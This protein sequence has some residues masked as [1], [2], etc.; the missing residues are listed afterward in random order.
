[1]LPPKCR[2]CSEGAGCGRVST[3]GVLLPQL[4]FSYTP[5]TAPLKTLILNLRMCSAH[6]CKDQLSSLKWENA[7][8]ITSR[9]TMSLP[10]AFH[11]LYF[12]T[13]LEN[14][15]KEW[16]PFRLLSWLAFLP[17]T[18][19][20]QYPC[21]YQ[22]TC[23]QI[24][25][26]KSREKNAKPRYHECFPPNGAGVRD[27]PTNT[28][29]TRDVGWSLGREDP[30]EEEMATHSSILAWRVPWTEESGGLWSTGSQSQTQLSTRSHLDHVV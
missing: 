10:S 26:I 5:Q 24:S 22:L 13:D 3:D 29:D 9:S 25:L 17:P 11:R 18:S 2:Q 27:I 6:K 20:L 16:K 4:F 12:K 23:L 21:F 15:L 14:C 28:G 19:I 1:M 8:G 7:K 30:L